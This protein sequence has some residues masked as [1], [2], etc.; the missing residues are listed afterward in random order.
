M[1]VAI[2]FKN[3]VCYTSMSLTHAYTGGS[4]ALHYNCEKIWE[5]GCDSDILSALATAR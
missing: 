5:G 2:P 3:T 4:G 1:K